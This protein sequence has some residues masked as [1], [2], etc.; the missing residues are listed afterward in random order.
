MVKCNSLKSI[1]NYISKQCFLCLFQ[2]K[3]ACAA[4]LTSKNLFFAL[5]VAKN[6][7]KLYQCDIKQLREYMRINNFFCVLLHSCSFVG[8][9]K[10]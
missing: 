5:V 2:T 10:V 9:L 4:R 7:F 1:I 6:K 3:W 8:M